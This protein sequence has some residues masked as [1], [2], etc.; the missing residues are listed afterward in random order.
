MW[1]RF[2]QKRTYK[3]MLLKLDLE[4]FELLVDRTGAPSSTAEEF[5]KALPDGEAR[6]AVFDQVIR[7]KYGGTNTRLYCIMWSPSTAGRSNMAYAT[8][9]K[10]LDAFFS[11]VEAKQ[12]TTRKAVLDV[13][14]AKKDDDDDGAFD[15]D[16]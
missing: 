1:L 5:A 9:R 7:N 4:R 12:C 3:W 14:S 2:K 11:G 6:Y 10:G 13:L 8:S 16:A 15:P